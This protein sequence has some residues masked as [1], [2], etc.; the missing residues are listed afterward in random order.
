MATYVRRDRSDTHLREFRSRFE[1]VVCSQ[2]ALHQ[3]LSDFPAESIAE[4]YASLEDYI[5]RISLAAVNLVLDQFLLAE[6][7]PALIERA[8]AH[9]EWATR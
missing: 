1:S 6:D 3:V 8:R 9:Y 5:G 7:V 4:R 2:D